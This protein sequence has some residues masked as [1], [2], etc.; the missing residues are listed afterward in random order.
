[1]KSVAKDATARTKRANPSSELTET[2]EVDIDVDSLTSDALTR[3]GRALLLVDEL[4]AD[5]S[6]PT[7]A[8]R[9]REQLAQARLSLKEARVPYLRWLAKGVDRQGSTRPQASEPTSSTRLVAARDLRLEDRLRDLEAH[10]AASGE[11][12]ARSQTHD[13]REIA[14]GLAEAREL[15]TKIRNTCD[16]LYGVA[17]GLGVDLVGNGVNYGSA[18]AALGRLVLVYEDIER[19]VAEL[20]SGR[21]AEGLSS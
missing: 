15:T 17:E 9:I 1:M 10:A 3:V 2:R 8:R 21:I 20:V 14:E 12:A 7:K 6:H 5:P 16:L 13:E 18:S 19:H 11:V 4:E